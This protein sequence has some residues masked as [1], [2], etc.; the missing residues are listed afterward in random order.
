[1]TKR[2]LSLLLA[3]IMALSLC[4]PAFAADEPEVIEEEPATIE[5]EGEEAA[6]VAADEPEAIA[7]DE[8]EVVDLLN[9]DSLQG[10]VNQANGMK[11]G[12]IAGWYQKGT[13]ADWPSGVTT[14]E[15]L[16]T[17]FLD[18]LEASEK[19]LGEIKDKGGYDTW[20]LSGGTRDRY[21][22]AMKGLAAAIRAVTKYV[23]EDTYRKQI[24]EMNGWI[25]WYQYVINENKTASYGKDTCDVQPWF[26]TEVKEAVAF[27]RSL[28]GYNED[29][30]ELWLPGAASILYKDYLAAKATF[31]KLYG[32]FDDAILAEYTDYVELRDAIRDA[33]AKLASDGYFDG[34]TYFWP[35]K[36]DGWCDSLSAFLDFLLRDI[37]TGA[38][39]TGFKDANQTLKS[40]HY[41]LTVIKAFLKENKHT[42]SLS[43]FYINTDF[44]S[45]SVRVV[46]SSGDK[47]K[48]DNRY[49]HLEVSAVKT[50]KGHPFT[51]AEL[52]DWREEDI[53]LGGNTKN[54]IF[55]M[56]VSPDQLGIKDDQGKLKDGAVITVKF[57]CDK[58]HEVLATKTIT[59][60]QSYNGPVIVDSEYDPDDIVIKLDKSLAAASQAHTTDPDNNQYSQATLTLSY[61]G[62]V[63]ET[64]T[65]NANNDLWKNVFKFNLTDLWHM[66]IGEY[67]VE[68]K[69]TQGQP[70]GGDHSTI[71]RGTVTV[72]VPDITA[73]QGD[74]VEAD[75]DD[76]WG[77][78]GAKGFNNLQKAIS[79]ANSDDKYAKSGDT[80]KLKAQLAANVAEAQAFVDKAATTPLSKANKAKVDELIAAIYGILKNFDV[81]ADTSALTAAIAAGEAL[82]PS[83]Y[84]G[85]NAWKTLQ[86]AITAGKDLMKK[87]PMAATA[88]NKAAIAA[89]AEAIE[90]AIDDLNEH[91]AVVPYNELKALEELIDSVPTRLAADDFSAA[92][93]AAVNAAVAA[94]K[95][96][97]DKTGVTKSE[98]QAA[99]DAV[100]A[101]LNNLTTV[102]S[103]AAPTAPSADYTGWATAENGDY[104]YFKNGSLVKADW[105]K[106]KGLWYHMGATGK[107]D[108][109]F[110]HIVD[111]WGDA[112]YY[113]NPS[114]TKGTMGRM[115]TGWKMINDS[116]AGA[117]G[118]FET[119]NNGHQGQCTYTTNWGDFKNY[120]PF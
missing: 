46:Q 110:I 34:A 56:D 1:M 9:E 72:T 39:T 54:G 119:R 62:T 36:V 118:W 67:T 75:E 26:E 8:P 114:N 84:D 17:Y 47:Y 29:Y 6:P 80:A 45:V 20:L 35:T 21:E 69:V 78:A 43:Q 64:K 98:L 92:S 42:L 93:K 10:M 82:V 76:V 81:A 100:Q 105:V 111:N 24:S 16:M 48:S 71:S 70:S 89:A 65:I 102:K 115:F 22:N 90:D 91:H 83:D 19:I 49:Y 107:M 50:V 74:E 99:I 95:P 101:A 41:Y 106:S 33:K 73:Y 30:D 44:K 104:Y 79:L 97:L 3:L 59:V 15:Q 12:I 68:L 96:L 55:E 117:W 112:Y 120:K 86:D 57:I 109:G 94:A 32:E 85:A 87:A 58:G 11:A 28:A 52:A 5:A 116:S 31:T 37:A 13:D 77:L 66:E 113:L 18:Q 40:V 4:V 103:D 88:A 53:G 2:V 63:V 51:A 14:D 38:G 27:L 60:D 7:V 25:K 61:N 23:R 108:T